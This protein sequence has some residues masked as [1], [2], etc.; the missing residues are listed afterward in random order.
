MTYNDILPFLDSNHNAM[1]V[2]FR[3]DGSAQTSIATCGPYQGGVAFT[4]TADRA[5]LANLR[6]NPRSTHSCIQAG[7]VQLHHGG[8]HS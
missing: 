4:T 5:K 8:R 6:R 2:T 3:R 1:V 7:L